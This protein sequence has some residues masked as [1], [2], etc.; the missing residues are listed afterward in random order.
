MIWRSPH[1]WTPLITPQLIKG[2]TEMGERWDV[3]ASKIGTRESWKH[4]SPTSK[5]TW[6]WK[7]HGGS[8]C[9][10]P[11]FGKNWWA[12]RLFP[13][14]DLKLICHKVS[15]TVQDVWFH[16]FEI[17]KYNPVIKDGNIEQQN[18]YMTLKIAFWHFKENYT[19]L[20]S[21]DLKGDANDDQTVILILDHGISYDISL[22]LCSMVIHRYWCLIT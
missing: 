13:I 17:S 5:T 11:F 18:S 3:D 6:G 12:L 15:Y 10:R 8:A 14:L 22:A 21:T 20:M 16:L 7:S 4:L 19:S 9:F 1:L 2:F